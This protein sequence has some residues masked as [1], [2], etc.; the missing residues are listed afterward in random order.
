MRITTFRL[1][2]FLAGAFI[3]IPFAASAQTTPTPAPCTGTN[4]NT[5][6]VTSTS[7][8]LQ[9]TQVAPLVNSSA[10]G[11]SVNTQIN[12]TNLGMNS[13]GPGVQCAS[14]QL[15]VNTYTQGLRQSDAGFGSNS[16][17]NGVNV[18]FVA[19]LGT[20]S[21]RACQ[22]LA[23]EILHQRQLDTQLTM[24]AKCGEF[25][26]AGLVLDPVVFPELTKVCSGV[27]LAV[28]ATPA[29]TPAPVVMVPEA[30][31]PPD[32]KSAEAPVA[33]LPK[34]LVAAA[35]VV[36]VPLSRAAA[37]TPMAPARKNALIRQLHIDARRRV[38][39]ARAEADGDIMRQLRAACV[40]DSAIFLALNS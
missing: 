8:P 15:A 2:L 33:V 24:I 35:R 10:A 3:S 28:A 34:A 30:S 23:D 7:Q 18:G 1:T 25:H 29:P 27:T 26:K 17:S 4:C 38:S 36:P 14:P 19:P 39:P 12:N 16:T 21:Q 20:R 9:Q 13:Y 31:P 11:T 22:A 37:C 6:T 5:T 40:P 32:A